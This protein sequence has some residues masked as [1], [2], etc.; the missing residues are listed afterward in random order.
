M[1]NLGD[2]M[3][4]VTQMQSRMQEAQARLETTMVEGRSG[5]G[6]VKVTMNGKGTVSQVSI[7][8]SL[9][10]PADKEILEDLLVTALTDARA[11]MEEA[12]AREMQA[13]TGGLPLPPGMKLP[14]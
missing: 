12:V 9:I 5:G 8:P 6:L 2:M 10:V 3:K 11:K 14:F 4:Q 13:V 7:D 1:K